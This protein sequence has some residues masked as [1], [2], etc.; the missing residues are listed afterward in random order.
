VGGR[1]VF[2]AAVVAEASVIACFRL[3]RI[4]FL[5]YNVVGCTVVMLVALALSAVWPRG[6]ARAG[7]GAAAA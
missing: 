2:V 6:A 3:S 7:T 5:W 4:S 1:A